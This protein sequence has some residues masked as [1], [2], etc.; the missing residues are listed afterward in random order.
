MMERRLFGKTGMEVSVLGFGGSEIG[1]EHTSSA[2]VDKLL[3]AA[4]DEGLNVVDTAACYVDSEEKIGAAVRHH[5]SQL[6]L[7]SK[8]GHASGLPS[9]DWTRE[10]IRDSIDRSLH[11]LRTDYIDLMQLHT[12]S[13][14]VLADGSVVEELIRA[15]EAGKVRFIGYSGDHDTA[16]QAVEMG[17]FDA[18]QT[19]INIADQ[20]VLEDVLPA[21]VQ[22][23]MGVIAKR[24][25]ANAAWK[26]K[27]LPSN[28]YHHVYWQRLREIDYDFL[29]GN[30]EEGVATALSFTL[31]CPGVSVA[32]VGT[33]NPGRW[34][35]NA[36]LLTERNLSEQEYRAIREQ[37]L[38]VA[39]PDWV[40]QT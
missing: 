17:V 38:A 6:Y 35:Q 1:Y 18:L 28:S 11:R 13:S 25:I 33:S 22:R 26:S 4:M 23:Q 34:K 3:G 7:F 2:T 21:A 37:Y 14:Q 27:E 29:H 9:A 10:T 31:S 30:L 5:R 20:R 36:L 19:S 32:I 12:C 39:K 40:G 16:L 15:K 8:C 24:P